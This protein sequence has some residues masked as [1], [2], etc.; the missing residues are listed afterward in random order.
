MA[1]VEH[2]A[3]RRNILFGVVLALMVGGLEY[4]GGLHAIDNWLGDWR[5]RYCQ[6]FVT[7]PTDRLI[8]V[9][10]DDSAL[11]S[12]GGWPWPRTEVAEILEE[13]HRAGAKAVGVDLIFSE[14]QAVSY[15]PNDAAAGG[16][17]AMKEV[18]HDAALTAAIRNGRAVVGASF[19]MSLQP[20]LPPDRQL[21]LRELT[22]DPDMSREELQQR[23]GSVILSDDEYLGLLQRAIGRRVAMALESGETS[24]DALQS[25]ILP[26]LSGFVGSP[27]ARILEKEFTRRSSAQVLNRFPQP[28]VSPDV[29]LAEVS[30]PLM[31]LT[32]FGEVAAGVG[33]VDFLPASDGVLRSIPLYISHD[34]HAV[35]QFGLALA[36]SY[37]GVDLRDVRVGTTAVE[38]PLPGGDYRLLPVTVR[39]TAAGKIGTSFDL[40]YFGGA[41][42][43]AMYG[44]DERHRPRQ[45]LAVGIL[46]EAKETRKRIARHNAQADE[47]I[48]MVLS[49]IDPAAARAP[50][51]QTLLG[52]EDWGARRSQINAVLRDRQVNYAVSSLAAM[53]SDEFAKL[54]FDEQEFMRAAQA[55]QRIV[56]QND[57]FET[58]L[59]RREHELKDQ[60]AGRAVLVG[61][62]ATG[63]PADF[64]TT[65]VQ[66][67]CPGEVVHATVFNAVL[68][69]RTWRR[70]PVA[71]AAA[72]TVAVGLLTTLAAA[73]LPGWKSL[74]GTFVLTAA[75][76]AI[77]GEL[78]FDRYGW[79]CNM[80]GPL[81]AISLSW[82]GVTLLRYVEEANLRA[83]VTRR[84]SSYVDPALVNYVVQHP[85]QARLKA[86]V[87]EM[88]VVFTDLTGFTAVAEMLKERAV[89]VLNDCARRMVPIIR[90]N[91]GYLNKFLG[92]G[93]MFSFGAP[94][95]RKDHALAAVQTALQMQAAMV[96]FSNSL[97]K[98]NIAR[99]PMRIGI[100]SGSMVVGDAG[101]DDACDYTALGDLVNLGS[102][103]EAA[104]KVFGTST[105]ISAVTADM[106]E[107][108]VLLRPIGR[109]MVVGKTELV[110]VYEPIC[111]EEEASA[112]QRDLVDLSKSV[113]DAF[114]AGHFR[115]C[116]NAVNMLE[117]IFGASEFCTLYRCV[118]DG[119]LATP[120][121]TDFKGALVL[122]GK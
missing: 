73:T 52:A 28:Q 102:R 41:D 68:T 56:T 36:C 30:T 50:S 80:A 48:R 78:L 11:E 3:V 120:P 23:A 59:H 114:I 109:L 31:P 115:E 26:R 33:F 81:F 86:E 75:F 84:F 20:A 9:D 21:L 111:P 5:A 45:H 77:N 108:R 100:S 63:S 22:R 99:M 34:G 14:R 16:I 64:V 43:M 61:W 97:A 82:A 24:L 121:S 76:L 95:E 69:G 72:V 2:R 35:P 83:R 58:L 67:R 46:Y 91:G 54:P 7:P 87:K 62:A 71:L 10:I 101:T 19:S 60:L 39:E 79:L 70:L 1:T 92:D 44:M 29:P 8:H 107:S 57:A 105:L 13:I 85:E 74:V 42:W 117:G 27:G 38:L 37:L 12:I 118:C 116:K 122:H 53:P 112:M 65:S 18:D 94:I 88:T 103:L 106:V 51:T 66:P 110:M 15:L 90:A 47:A 89:E 25:H 96:D 17:G 104:N 55:L 93:L 49:T 98:R 32:R 4:W 113:V 6:A 40:P 119:H